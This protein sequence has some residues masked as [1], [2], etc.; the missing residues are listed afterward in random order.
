[1]EPV[2]ARLTR[3]LLQP[4]PEEPLLAKQLFLVHGMLAL[5]LLQVL[6]K[7]LGLCQETQRSVS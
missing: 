5:T 1:M 4:S 6:D 7:T 3:Q 2:Q